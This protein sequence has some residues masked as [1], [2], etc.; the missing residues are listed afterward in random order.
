MTASWLTSS[1]SGDLDDLLAL[2]P[3]L[4]DQRQRLL[5]RLWDDRL[6]D[7]VVL[8]LCR[9]RIAALVG[10]TEALTLRT[11]HAVADGLSDAKAA[12]VANWA[13]DPQFTAGERAALGAAELFVIDVRS[14]DATQPNGL[15]DHFTPDERYAMLIA[16]ALFD[17]FGRMHR[18]LT[19]Q[20]HAVLIDDVLIDDVP[21]K[22]HR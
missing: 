14:L 6:V 5:G 11:P 18:V 1:K 9:L 8:E 3:D 17:G 2:R 21:T 15:N 22:G 20:T 13:T 19:D 16:F 12:S 4:A 7:P 10:D